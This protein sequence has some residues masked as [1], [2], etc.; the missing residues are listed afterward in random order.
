MLR[1]TFSF[2]RLDLDI[3]SMVNVM[4]QFLQN[5]RDTFVYSEIGLLR[6][7]SNL[8]IHSKD[9]LYDLF[10]SAVDDP[11]HKIEKAGSYIHVTHDNI[12]FIISTKTLEIISAVRR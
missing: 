3:E 12:T 2:E 9:E 8:G 11:I 5:N 7:D 1:F 4:E 6:A 10:L